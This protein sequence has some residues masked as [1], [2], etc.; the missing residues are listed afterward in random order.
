[1]KR[2]CSIL[3]VIL[4]V[5]VFS[6]PSRSFAFVGVLPVYHVNY[7]LQIS[8]LLSL[9]GENHGIAISCINI[10]CLPPGYGPTPSGVQIGGFNGS[11]YDPGV[12]IGAV[13]SGKGFQ[14]GGTNFRG[15]Q[16]F[17]GINLSGGFQFGVINSGRL[18]KMK[19]SGWWSGVQ[20]GG[21]NWNM[22]VNGPVGLQFGGINWNMGD[23]SPEGLQFGVINLSK[24]DIGTDKQEGKQFGIINLGNGL[25]FGLLNFNKNG[26]LPVMP[27][28]NLSIERQEQEPEQDS[29]GK[30]EPQ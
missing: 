24:L 22:G 1:M 4:L 16:Q 17:G 14:V 20:F 27:F 29:G 19:D 12:Q 18:Y 21:I 10:I 26:L 9:G 25:Q 30:K 3:S 23:E 13:N 6:F 2:I 7:F 5:S 11:T 15:R 8:P 28:F